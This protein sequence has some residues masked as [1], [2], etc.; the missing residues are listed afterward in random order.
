VLGA[1]L[2]KGVRRCVVGG[3]PVTP[4]ARVTAE[5]AL[6]GACVQ[7]EWAGRKSPY[8][9]LVV[10]AFLGEPLGVDTHVSS[11]PALGARLSGF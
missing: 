2:V 5:P 11:I 8:D 1:A 3:P 4:V 6:V 9:F 7:A 10:I